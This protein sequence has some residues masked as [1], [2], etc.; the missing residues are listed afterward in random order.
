MHLR[1][2]CAHFLPGTPFATVRIDSDYVERL[3]RTTTQN[4]TAAACKSNHVRTSSSVNTYSGVC[5]KKTQLYLYHLQ[6][7][8]D[9]N[10]NNNNFIPR[11]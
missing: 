9:N 4:A 1:F 10:N 7:V 8:Y 3:E 11:G 5:S 2:C 6:C